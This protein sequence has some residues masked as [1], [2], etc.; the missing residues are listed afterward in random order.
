[1]EILG[2]PPFRAAG[3]E[4]SGGEQD[5]GGLKGAPG[6]SP[7]ALKGASDGPSDVPDSLKGAPETPF[8]AQDASLKGAPEDSLPDSLKG[9]P[10][11]FEGSDPSFEG[12]VSGF[13]GSAQTLP[14]HV[15]LSSRSNSS[16]TSSTTVVAEAAEDGSG[17]SDGTEEGGGGGESSSS[18]DQQQD[19]P[20]ARAESFVDSLDY[21]GKQPGQTRRAKL[22]IRV[23][24]AFK[25]GWTE[26]G[27]R[28]YLD[29]SD[30]PNVRTP[31]AVYAHRLSEDELPEAAPD[32]ALPPA[33]W[34][35]L[36][37]N[38]AAATDL[39][40]RINPI[41]CDP[42]P[43][44]HPASVGQ[45]PEV[46]PVCDAC[47]R[48]NPAAQF[49]I[50]FRYRVI[51]GVHQGCPD[52]HPTLV[53]RQATQDGADG[54]MWDRAM[55]RA[56]QRMQTG[57]WRGAGPDER[58]AGWAAVADQLRDS[59]SKTD[60]RVHQAVQAGRRLQA[61]DDRR[62]A[63]PKLGRNYSND[64]WQQPADPAKA[65]KIPHC[66][67]PNCD[68]VT[69]LKTEPDWTG[70]PRTAVCGDCHPAMKF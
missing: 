47:V 7:K 32:A 19:K 27:L 68:P 49:N 65:A 9:A 61:Q 64:V 57:D 10:G 59:P 22:T 48:A 12:S 50:R 36:G 20:L 5:S 15:V 70:E 21:R 69:R 60:Q 63:G 58:V 62:K 30:D 45:S 29:I 3:V 26:N 2:A 56:R 43:N 40:L 55:D 66:G 24:A 51:D 1:M 16:R 52:C 4:G 53:A 17:G 18:E 35:C 34:D 42:C 38:P 46:P 67:D 25:D 33:C 6:D 11:V 23:A 31:A 28:R 14:H 41:T 37:L 39:T 44:C 8:N 54:G 13:E